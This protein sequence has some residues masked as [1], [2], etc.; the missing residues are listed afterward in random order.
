MHNAYIVT[1]M[2]TNERTVTLDEAL[3]L[4]STKVRLV[5]EPLGS[6]SHRSYQEIVVAIRERQ[7]ARGHRPPTTEEVDAYLQAERDSWGK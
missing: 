7:E 6:A 4:P 5:V 2:L 1:G 3:P